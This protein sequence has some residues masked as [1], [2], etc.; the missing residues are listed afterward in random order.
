MTNGS[1]SVLG[2]GSGDGMRMTNG[3]SSVLGGGSGDG[4]RMTNGSSSVLGGGSGDGMQMTNG[5]SFI[6]G[7]GSGDGMRMTNGSSFIL[8]GGSGRDR[9]VSREGGEGFA[10]TI[11]ASILNEGGP[12]STNGLSEHSD[13]V[14]GSPCGVQL[15]ESVRGGAITRLDAF[16]RL[17]STFFLNFAKYLEIN[18]SGIL[19]RGSHVRS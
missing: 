14:L 2:G 11:S 3:S 13:I 8:G 10:S 19:A 9:W 1:S 6:L 18:S 5:S 15:K 17:A 12:A 7:G 4:M 16:L